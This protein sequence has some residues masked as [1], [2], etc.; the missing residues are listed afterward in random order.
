MNQR[1]ETPAAIRALDL[2]EV[3][4]HLR[5]VG[6]DEDSHLERLMLA[7]EQWCEAETGR[8]LCTQTWKFRLDCFP[9]GEI[10]VPHPPLQSIT[11]IQYVDTAGA[12]QTLAA[13]DY[14]VDIYTEPARV[15]SGYG[16]SWPATREVYNAV[17]VTAVCGYLNAAAVPQKLKQAMLL[18]LAHLYEH[19]EEVS[20][21]QT[22]QVPKASEW[23]AAP[24]RVHVF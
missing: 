9:C 1:L 20:D 8:A 24:Y 6:T 18:V 14:Q 11:A 13:P 12:T 16:L 5:I 21:F 3:K 15:A 19:R 2:D 10:V 17:T 22:F 4:A 23:L 7:A